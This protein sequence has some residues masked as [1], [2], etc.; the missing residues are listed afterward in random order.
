MCYFLQPLALTISQSLIAHRS[1]NNYV[2]KLQYYKARKFK[3]FQAPTLF[4]RT[5]K[6]AWESRF[7]RC[8]FDKKI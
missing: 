2:H 1:N 4:S 8:N 7:G 3:D 6:D 5:F